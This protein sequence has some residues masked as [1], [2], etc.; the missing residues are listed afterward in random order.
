MQQCVFFKII[1]RPGFIV[2]AIEQTK[3]TTIHEKIY[4][5][6]RTVSGVLRKIFVLIQFYFRNRK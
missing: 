5:F 3:K 6:N 1:Q 4:L 2:R